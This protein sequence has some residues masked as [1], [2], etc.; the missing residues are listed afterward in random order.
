[1]QTVRHNDNLIQKFAQADLIQHDGEAATYSAPESFQIADF[2]SN[3]AF[4]NVSVNSSTWSVSGL[5]SP[6]LEQLQE[7]SNVIGSIKSLHQQLTQQGNI[8]QA[9][10]GFNIVR[11]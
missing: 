9:F 2:S 3:D 6:T 7:L 11:Q 4:S 5:S 10:T 1:M 8:I